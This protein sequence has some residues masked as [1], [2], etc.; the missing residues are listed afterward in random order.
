MKDL[1]YSSLEELTKLKKENAYVF[2]QEARRIP[3]SGMEFRII[4]GRLIEGRTPNL[5]LEMEMQSDMI[6]IT[7]RSQAKAKKDIDDEILSIAK[8]QY[9]YDS[10]L[11]AFKEAEAKLFKAKEQLDTAK[12]VLTGL[13]NDQD[14]FTKALDRQKQK[15]KNMENYILMHKSA[16]LNQA[17]ENQYGT[18][19]VT[20]Y[21]ARSLREI[22]FV[23]EVFQS[24]QSL[25][26][27]QNIPHSLE[28]SNYSKEEKQGMIDY[29]EMLIYYF[30]EH[31]GCKVVPVFSSMEIA[32][33]L[34]ANGY[35]L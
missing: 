9:E 31:D 25:G 5:K 29:A 13:K 24:N 33:L 11:K 8:C 30:L 23:D 27:I 10:C 3:F 26:F 19:V 28:N 16:I 22:A 35:E 14:F 1:R 21:D 4:R 2:A 20:E 17:I 15:G 32:E 34:K 12:N 18:Y 6:E 7:K